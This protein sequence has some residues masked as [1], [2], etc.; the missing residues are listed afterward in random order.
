MGRIK[1]VTPNQL[2]KVR[3]N[4]IKQKF[5]FTN[6]CFDILHVGHIRYFQKAKALG[7]I[8]IIGLNSDKSI[9]AIKGP[10][11]PIIPLHERAE[12]LSAIEYIDYII[13]FDKPSPLDLILRVHPDILVKGE[14]WE[15]DNIIG[16]KEVKEYGGRVERIKFTTDTSTSKI[17]KMIVEGN[18]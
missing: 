11:R 2:T 16:A 5:V 10:N 4:L 9:R 15:E 3:R 13:V 8:L 1:I 18:Y 14:D 12:V 7:D 6:G 17:I